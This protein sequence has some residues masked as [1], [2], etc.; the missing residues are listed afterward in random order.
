[1]K[2]I[3]I[4]LPKTGTKT[5]GECCR[6]W[7]LNHQ[8]WDFRR[9]KLLQESQES[10][11]FRFQWKKRKINKIM[12]HVEKFDSFDDCP[13]YLLYR[14]I[15]ERFPGSKFIL[16]KR[17]SADAWFESYC[18][19]ADKLVPIPAIKTREHV[20]GYK[21]PKVHK[22]AYL[23]VYH[24]HN[25]ADQEYF[26]DKPGQMMEICWEDGGGWQELST[27]LEFEIPAMPFPHINRR[28]MNSKD[29]CSLIVPPRSDE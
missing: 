28:S 5:L 17:K 6:I 25:E 23:R 13:W 11:C 26:K 2:I 12:R 15:D 29:I 14:E 9:F 21:H 20:F 8:S 19:W 18:K 22:E 4:G 24:A 3:G 7:G 10:Y 16:T 27:F 1:M